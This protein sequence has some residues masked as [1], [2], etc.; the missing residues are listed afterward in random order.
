MS[1]SYA[2]S[3]CSQSIT[4]PAAFALCRWLSNTCK[5]M[6][7]PFGRP[8]CEI[9]DRFGLPSVTDLV[10]Q[11]RHQRQPPGGGELGDAN[12]GIDL[13]IPQPIGEREPFRAD[14]SQ[15]TGM[16]LERSVTIRDRHSYKSRAAL[17]HRQIS[18]SRAPAS[19]RKGEG[20]LRAAARAATNFC[21]SG[22]SGESCPAG[23]FFCSDFS[24]PFN[25]RKVKGTRSCGVTKSVW[26]KNTAARKATMPPRRS[27]RRRRGHRLPAGSEKIK[28]V[29][30]LGKSASI[31]L[32]GR[33]S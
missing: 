7:L 19:S 16:L 10:G 11:E 21:Q 24:C 23:F 31:K 25:W 15:F 13:Q 1:S 29:R 9:L 32:R 4:T 6:F 18:A 28:G 26:T 5:E 8:M 33:I 30:S 12:I 27:A 2:G 17:R 20:C 22:M 14:M 3:T